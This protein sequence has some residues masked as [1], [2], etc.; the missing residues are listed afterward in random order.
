ME[1]LLIVL[2]VSFSVIGGY[3]RENRY[4]LTI[5]VRFA[6]I[7]NGESV[8]WG[9]CQEPGTV[10]H[11]CDHAMRTNTYI[12]VEATVDGTTYQLACKDGFHRCP[13]LQP[14]HTYR[15]R[16]VKEGRG[17]ELQEP[18]STFWAVAAGQSN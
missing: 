3:A 13:M 8:G 6:R 18:K 1:S 4:P 17:I 7:T 16:W 11:L 2:L 5:D 14:H 10:P 15:A 9:T 12:L